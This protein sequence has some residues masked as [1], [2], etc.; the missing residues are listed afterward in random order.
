MKEMFKEEM[1]YLSSD[2]SVGWPNEIS[3]N[4]IAYVFAIAY[5]IV[6][7]TIY[8]ICFVPSMGT[9]FFSKHNCIA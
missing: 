6:M 1:G 5:S 8:V 3:M 4:P 9:K 2:L 7:I